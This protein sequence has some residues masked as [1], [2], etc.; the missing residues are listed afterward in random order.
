MIYNM[1]Y[2]ILESIASADIAFESWATTIECLFCDTADALISVMVN[3][4]G[5]IAEHNHLFLEQKS[6]SLDMLLYRVL[7]EL[8]FLKDSKQMFYRVKDVTIEERVEAIHF[9]GTLYGEKIDSTRHQLLVDVKAV[10]LH[11]FFVK[12]E[13]FLWKTQVILDI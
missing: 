8:I 12:K 6:K 9:R 11:D 1:P 5:A 2:R 13:G 4:I 7:E 10:T 3:N